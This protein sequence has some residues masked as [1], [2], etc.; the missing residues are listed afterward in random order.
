MR[1]MYTHCVFSMITLFSLSSDLIS[2]LFRFSREADTSTSY[3]RNYNSYSNSDYDSGKGGTVA[4]G[5]C[6]LANLG[7][8][9]FMNSA[10]QVKGCIMSKTDALCQSSFI[11]NTGCNITMRLVILKMETSQTEHWLRKYFVYLK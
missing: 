11:F 3:T 9:C 4:P 2:C 5:L 8:T 6:G 10:I 1:Y 7:N